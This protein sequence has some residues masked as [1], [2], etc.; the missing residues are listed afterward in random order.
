MTPLDIRLQ[1]RT[2][3][4]SFALFVQRLNEKNILT[5]SV[6]VSIQFLAQAL[7]NQGQE[8]KLDLAGVIELE[9]D[10]ELPFAS[11]SSPDAPTLTLMDYFRLFRIQYPVA[12][13]R[14]CIEEAD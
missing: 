8:S 3:V 7:A 12:D 2:R 9:V 5:S 10:L 4:T 13:H 11:S 1:A 14:L 6:R